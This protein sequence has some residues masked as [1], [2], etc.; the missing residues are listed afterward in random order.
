MMLDSHP[1]FKGFLLPE[2]R[3]QKLLL[4]DVSQALSDRLQNCLALGK[5]QAWRKAELPYLS[6]G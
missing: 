4:G 2:I 1:A 5:Q 6:T 3:G